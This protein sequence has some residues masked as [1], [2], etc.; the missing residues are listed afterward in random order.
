MAGTTPQTTDRPQATTA[1]RDDRFP[2]GIP[3]IVGNEAAERFSFYGMRQ[4]LYVYLVG[5]FLG[6]TAEEAADPA[7]VESAR[8]HATQVQHLFIAGAYLSPLIG[9]ILA[10]RLWGKYKVIFWISLLYVVGHAA[11]A[12]GGRFGALGD[13]DGARVGMFAGLLLIALGAGGIKPCV[14]ANVGDQFTSKNAHLVPRIFQ[15]FYFTINFGSFFAS[16]LTPWLYQRYG[17]EV[18]FGVPGVL[19]GV[20]TFVFWLGRKRFVRVPPSPGGSI[21]R[22][23]FAASSL[24]TIPLLILIYILLEESEHLVDAATSGGA[25]A[26]GRALATMSTQYLWHVVVAAGAL[27]AGVIVAQLRQARQRDHGFLAVLIYS[28]LHRRERR[29][30]EDFWGPARRAFGDEAA[31]GPPAVLRIIVVFSMVSVFWALFDQH[32]STWVEQAK[33]MDLRLVVPAVV[34]TWWFIPVTIVSAI[35]GALWLLLWVANRPM[36]RATVWAFIGLIVAWGLGSVAVQAARGESR[37]IDLLASQISALNPLLIMIIIPV[38]NLLVLRPLERRG[39][40]MSPLARM[41][42]GM[43]LAAASFAA[44]AVLQ[45]RIEAAPPGSIPVLWQLVP[46]FVLTTSEVLISITGLEFAYTQAPRAM[47]STIMGFWFLCVTFG[48]VLVAF[49]APLQKLSLGTFFWTFA[50]IMGAAAL[51]FALLA[52]RYRGKTY[53]QS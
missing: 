45:R 34:W 41:T 29:P 23:D 4:I 40:P 19:M 7:L 25:A 44:V 11:L 33:A 28:F 36:R 32:S 6:F 18:A 26:V 17:A 39:R 42:L 3:Y 8:V 27:V 5:L 1:P 38:L 43:F 37:T 22:L 9:A 47:K 20:A 21:G 24:M 10:D 46:Y 52:S 15:I 14:S 31:E 2:P 51:L 35:F 50:A 49:L 53:M 13:L 48:N 12:I 30:D 16:V